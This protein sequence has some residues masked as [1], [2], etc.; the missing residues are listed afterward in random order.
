MSCSSNGPSIG[1]RDV[2]FPLSFNLIC[3]KKKRDTSHTHLSESIMPERFFNSSMQ[4]ASMLMATALLTD[5][6]NSAFKANMPNVLYLGICK[7]S[8]LG[9]FGSKLSHLI[10]FSLLSG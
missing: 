6:N 1:R 10:S 4:Q 7:C 9:Y 3:R 2:N 8:L 5:F